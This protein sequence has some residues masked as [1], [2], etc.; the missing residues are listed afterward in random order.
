MNSEQLYSYIKNSKNTGIKFDLID[1]SYGDRYYNESGQEYK[2]TILG[3]Q[4]Q[5]G[6]SYITEDA[7]DW[8]QA[9][10]YQVSWTRCDDKHIESDEVFQLIEN[11]K[12]ENRDQKLKELGI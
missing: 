3:K 9:E 6:Y 8:A 4:Y 10:C 7:D 11:Y 12:L 2:F 5:V 1:T